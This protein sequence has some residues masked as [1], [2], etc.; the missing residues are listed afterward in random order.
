[1][2]LVLLAATQDLSLEGADTAAGDEGRQQTAAARGVV[3][4]TQGYSGGGSAC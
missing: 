4:M 2:I 3:H 1:M